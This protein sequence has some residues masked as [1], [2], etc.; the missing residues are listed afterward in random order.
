MGSA[1]LV[2]LPIIC[3]IFLA[4][5]QLGYGQVMAPS[6]APEGP[7]NDGYTIDQGIAY[8]LMLLALAVTYLLH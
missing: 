6:P 7:S 4:I 5:S 1:K 8:V 2:A 3:F